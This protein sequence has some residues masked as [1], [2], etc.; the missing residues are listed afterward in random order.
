LSEAPFEHWLT[1][2]AIDLTVEF[3]IYLLLVLEALEIAHL[4]MSRTMHAI[5]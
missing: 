3:A 2:T 1:G 4:V 5:L